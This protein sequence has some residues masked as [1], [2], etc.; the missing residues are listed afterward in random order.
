MKL[1][2]GVYIQVTDT[3]EK[4]IYDKNVDRGKFAF[5]AEKNGEF[6]TCFINKDSRER[7]IIYDP[8]TGIEA[9]DYSN[10]ATKENLK[11]LEVQL[12]KIEELAQEAESLLKETQMYEE[13]VFADQETMHF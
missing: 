9:K 12:K 10:V 7:T 2:K 3:E 6:V 4:R 11:P 8:T 5:A 13:R 1:G